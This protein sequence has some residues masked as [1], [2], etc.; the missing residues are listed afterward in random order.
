MKKKA[1]ELLQTRF[2]GV[3]SAILGRIADKIVKTTESEEDLAAAVESVTFQQLLESYGDSRATEAQ[4]TAIENFKKKHNIIIDEPNAAQTAPKPQPQ[5]ATK[6]TQTEGDEMPA[7]AKAL[8]ESNKALSAELAK[9]K[10]EKVSDNRKSALSKVVDKL[11]ESIK[12]RYIK[13][14]GRLQFQ[15]DADFN[16][17]LDEIKPEVDSI[18]K[19]YARPKF[20]APKGGG[21]VK[22]ADKID[23]NLQARIDERAKA[24]VASTA[25]QGLPK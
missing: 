8:V 15:D 7:W 18:V 14:F 1:L 2:E 13:D 16:S 17:W 4:Q 11:P 21:S 10:G 5:P 3:S 20:G 19:D 22:Q 23:P 24:E 9:I 12:S 6:Q 25:I